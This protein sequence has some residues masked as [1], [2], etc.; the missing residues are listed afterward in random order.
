MQRQISIDIQQI[1]DEWHAY[2]GIYN[3]GDRFVNVN[4][5]D[6]M[7]HV[8]RSANRLMVKLCNEK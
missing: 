4:F 6:L 2:V 7:D 3:D 8:K 1:G 5:D